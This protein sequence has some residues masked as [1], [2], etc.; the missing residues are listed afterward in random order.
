MSRPFHLSIYLLNYLHTY[1]A[2]FC[3]APSSTGTLAVVS[4]ASVRVIILDYFQDRNPYLGPCVMSDCA[5]VESVGV[6]PRTGTLER[7][8][9]LSVPRNGQM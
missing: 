1:P 2:T 9:S 6:H 3:S 8:F 5:R 4:F 7:F